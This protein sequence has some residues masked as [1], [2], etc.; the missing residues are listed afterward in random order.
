MSKGVIGLKNRG[1]T[2]Y[3][4]TSIQ[5]LSH[6]P[7][8][9]DYFVSNDYIIDLNNRFEE[10][11]T[12]NIKE[13]LLTREY[14]KLIKAMWSNTSSIEPKSFHELIQKIDDR[15]SGYEQQDSQEALSLIL[16]HLH[17]GLKYDVDI[18]YTGKNENKVDELVIES[19]KQWSSE[20]KNKYSII[21]ELF[22]G[23]FMNKIVSVEK[24]SLL[25]TKFE[26]FNMLSVPIYGNTLYDSLAKYFEKETL[27]TPFFDEK[28]NKNINAYKRIQLVKVPKYLIIVLKRY[29]NNLSKSNNTITFPIN[30][31]DLSQYCSG[32]DQYGCNLSL[33]SIGCHYGGLS[34][35]HY[36]SICKHT[37]GKWYK[38]DDDD[39]SELSIENNLDALFKHGYILIYEKN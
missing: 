24:N 30:H 20:L 13:I 33:V 17:E 29:Q 37:N 22:F 23:Q 8:L 4:N 2:C 1:N 34:G 39:A 19:I 15:F 21:V 38:Y 11:K 26:V 14:S 16:D 5:C 7:K 6:I 36:Y 32:Y 25:S 9:T 18:T 28:K 27:E 3:L 31:L 12:K 35:G 10:I